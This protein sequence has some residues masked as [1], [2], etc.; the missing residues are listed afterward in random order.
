M[1]QNPD[2]GEPGGW[3]I[4]ALFWLEWEKGFRRNAKISAH[5]GFKRQNVDLR[6]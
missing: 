2:M 1:S 4:Q 3:P 6:F 5:S